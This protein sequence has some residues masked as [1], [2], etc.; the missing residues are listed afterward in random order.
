VLPTGDNEQIDTQCDRCSLDGL[1]VS[2][3]LFGMVYVILS[4]CYGYVVKLR[5]NKINEQSC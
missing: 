1:V 2:F 4:K 5:F 3:A